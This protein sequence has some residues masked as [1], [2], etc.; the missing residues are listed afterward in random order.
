MSS[1]YL[2]D[3]IAQMNMRNEHAYIIRL[4]SRDYWYF[5][6]VETSVDPHPI[7]WTSNISD[8]F[9]F[10]DE[11][12]V[13]EFKTDFIAPRQVEILRVLRKG[14]FAKLRKGKTI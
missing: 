3:M 4:T 9:W 5:F 1:P 7:M 10:P 6:D 8:A 14:A 11:Q 13:E 12:S 2:D